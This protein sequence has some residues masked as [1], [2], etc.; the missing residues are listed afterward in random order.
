MEVR[1]RALSSHRQGPTLDVPALKEERR[2]IGCEVNKKVTVFP[3]WHPFRIPSPSS[4]KRLPIREEKGMGHEA[5]KTTVTC[6]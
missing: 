1:G 4:A 6:G 2:T 5:A 3:V